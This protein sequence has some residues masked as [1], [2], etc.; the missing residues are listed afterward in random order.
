MVVLYIQLIHETQIEMLEKFVLHFI[1]RISGET[2]TRHKLPDIATLLY[3]ST[4]LRLALV[5]LNRTFC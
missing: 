1:V 2:S 4:S 3:N 5:G